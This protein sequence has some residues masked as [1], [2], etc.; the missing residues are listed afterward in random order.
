MKKFPIIIALVTV[1][2]IV[3]GVIF[4][5]KDSTPQSYPLPT[6]LEYYWGEGCP[7]CKNVEDFME[8]WDKKD[9]VTI[10]KSEVWNNP[11]NAAKMQARYDYCQIPPTQMGVPLLFTPDGKCYSGDTPIIDYFKSL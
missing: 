5:S 1:V 9:D 3:G 7:H 2:I 10:E 6:N 8:G 4:V 11:K